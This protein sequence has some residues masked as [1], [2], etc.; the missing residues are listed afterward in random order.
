M[1][2]QTFEFK[3]STVNNFKHS[4]SYHFGDG[5]NNPNFSANF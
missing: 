4:C 5:W 2:R 3:F 1:F